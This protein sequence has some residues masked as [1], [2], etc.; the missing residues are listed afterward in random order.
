MIFQHEK[1]N[2]HQNARVI[3]V[4]THS[5]E[6]YGIKSDALSY[7]QPRTNKLS[8]IFFFYFPR[9]FFLNVIKN[10]VLRFVGYFFVQS[11][12]LFTQLTMGLSSTLL[13]RIRYD[14]VIALMRM[15]GFFLYNRFR[16]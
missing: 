14:F 11:F 16:F 8:W 7:L 3:F 4:F 6:F 15:L 10:V 12:V 5:K 9:I 13:I 2:H 1:K